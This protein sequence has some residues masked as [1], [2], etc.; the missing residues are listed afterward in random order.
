MAVLNHEALGFESDFPVL[1]GLDPVF[2]GESPKLGVHVTLSE[3]TKPYEKTLHLIPRIV[4]IGVGCRR[5]KDFPTIEAHVLEALKQNNI[6]MAAVEQLATIDLKKDEKGLISLCDKY[7][8]KFT[9]YS[10]EELEAVEGEFTN[11]SF[12]GNITGVQNVCERAAVLGSGYGH[13][14]QKK[15]AD[16]G[17]TVAIAVKEWSVRFE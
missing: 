9:C 15:L 11:S 14:I 16:N 5:D 8:L 7:G 3:D 17:V 2:R 4:T 6:S 10:S 1:G 13:L 12:V